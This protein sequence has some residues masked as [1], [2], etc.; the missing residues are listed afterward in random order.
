MKA[1][2]F[3]PE[4][5]EKGQGFNRNDFNAYVQASEKL[6]R[7]L[8]TKYLPSVA[9]GLVLGLLF[10]QGVGGIAGNVLAIVCIFAGLIV[11]GIFNAKAGKAA[12]A[13]AQ[14]LGITKADVAIARRHVKNGTYA[15]RGSET[16][17][18]CDEDQVQAGEAAPVLDEPQPV[19]ALPEK[20]MRAVWATALLAVSWF[21]LAW[22]QMRFSQTLLTSSSA[23]ICLSAAL[24]GTGVHLLTKK[25]LRW[26]LVGGGIGLASSLLLASSEFVARRVQQLGRKFS[27][28]LLFSFRDLN[29]MRIF[30][31]VLLAVLLC[32]GAA[33]VFSALRRGLGKKQARLCGVMAGGVY[34]LVRLL[35]RLQMLQLMFSRLGREYSMIQ[36]LSQEIFPA[37]LAALT[38]CFVCMVAYALCHMPQTRVKLRGIGLVWAWLALAGSLFTIFIIFRVGT[39]GA[40]AAGIRGVFAFQLILGL[41]ALLGYALLLCKRHVGLYF[42]LLGVGLMLGAQVVNALSN[43]RSVSGPQQLISALL[44]AVN[45]LFAW[46]AVRAG[47][48]PGE[49]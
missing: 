45:P 40:R 26:R 33:L 47:K 16:D 31:N 19:P 37:L 29:Y 25:E 38:I 32:L 9:V 4:H 36:I 17:T 21:L 12:N 8:Y 44:G 7:T 11:G 35:P 2:D 10:S 20:P 46:L 43:I 49:P 34:L 14:R 41:S 28:S 15:W 30:S 27:F 48:A 18:V 1:T 39:L 22:F 6:A 13:L 24:L 3:R 23:Y 5:F 42:I